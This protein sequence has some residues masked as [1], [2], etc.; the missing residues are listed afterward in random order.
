MIGGK[1]K[2]VVPV[3]KGVNRVSFV[4]LGRESDVRSPDDC[5]AEDS[6]SIISS[7]GGAGKGVAKEGR[8]I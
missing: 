3:L 1:D 8:L 6:D 4:K 2:G 7:G 5:V